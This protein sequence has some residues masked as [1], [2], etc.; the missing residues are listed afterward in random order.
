M[1]TLQTA[2]AGAPAPVAVASKAPSVITP[3]V[4]AHASQLDVS[5]RSRPVAG[6]TVSGDF[7]DVFPIDD[8]TWGLL[9][10]DA[11]GSGETAAPLA[12][13]A[14][15]SVRT[16]ATLGCSP[17]WALRQANRVLVRGAG[18]ADLLLATAVLGYATPTRTGVDVRLVSAGHV[19]PLIV[20][21]DR[22]ETAPVGGPLLGAFAD[23][24]IAP[25]LVHLGPGDLLVLCTDGVTE[26]RDC[27]GRLLGDAGLVAAVEARWGQPAALV[28]ASVEQTALAHGASTL[29]DDATVLVVTA[30][31]RSAPRSRFA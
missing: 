26:A 20:R 15:Q 19:P 2:F 9:V 6:Q 28:A 16:Y 27:T 29:R 10:G 30:L 8:W 18:P 21:R 12:A 1:T 24:S 22:V 3:A 5:V 25:W 7:W 4:P 14:H 11:E 17:G 13:L 31:P 23:V